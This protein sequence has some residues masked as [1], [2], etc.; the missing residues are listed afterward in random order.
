MS[1]TLHAE[2]VG[3]K[4][5]R[6]RFVTQL[7]EGAV[8]LAAFNDPAPCF[9]IVVEH[10]VDTA[11]AGAHCSLDVT[12]LPPESPV[13]APDAAAAASSIYVKL[14]GAELTWRPGHATLQCDPAYTD[15]LL[16]ALAEFTHYERELRQIESEIAS[17]WADLEQDK[18]LAF[19][20]T[21]ADLA[22]REDVGSRMNQAFARRIRYAR[23]EPHLYEPGA[24]LSSAGQKLGAELRERARIEARLETADAQLEVYEHIYE[25]G[26]QRLGEFRASHEEHKLEWIII[27]LLAA[28]LV[29]LL[30]QMVWSFKR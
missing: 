30:A 15:A 11:A 26:G 5:L 18:S 16:P 1:Q 28:E 13:A 4:V 7:P 24:A 10:P 23:I 19:D 6:I 21:P 20:V 3:I 22:R 8:A 29:A 25:M 2:D 9:A 17:G 27:V 14:R 12:L